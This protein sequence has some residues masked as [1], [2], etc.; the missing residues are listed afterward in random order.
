VFVKERRQP[1]RIFLSIL[2][3][4]RFPQA[5]PTIEKPNKLTRFKLLLRINHLIFIFL[6]LFFLLWL[7]LRVVLLLTSSSS[8]L[9]PYFLRC[10]RILSFAFVAGRSALLEEH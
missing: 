2:R 7:I 9:L 1:I 8:V 6:F 10:A 5:F 3:D 4:T